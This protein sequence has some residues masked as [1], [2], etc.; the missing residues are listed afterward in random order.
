MKQKYIAPIV[1][2]ADADLV[3][4]ILLFAYNGLDEEDIVPLDEIAAAPELEGYDRQE[5]MAAI[6]E[7][8]DDERYMVLRPVL[9]DCQKHA[10]MDVTYDGCMFMRGK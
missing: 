3:R 9:Y 8:S 2:K 10:V 1:E 4:K 5:I 6:G 7:I